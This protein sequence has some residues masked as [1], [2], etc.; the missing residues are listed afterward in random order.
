[1]LGSNQENLSES[2]QCSPKTAS[3]F[4]CQVA[5]SENP[6]SLSG[7]KNNLLSPRSDIS[8]ISNM[9]ID[10]NKC[11]LPYEYDEDDSNSETSSNP[12]ISPLTVISL[13]LDNASFRTAHPVMGPELSPLFIDTSLAN[14]TFE[15]FVTGNNL[16]NN[17]SQ[18][19]GYA[20]FRH[21][22]SNIRPSTP[23]TPRPNVPV[24]NTCHFRRRRPVSEYLE[25]YSR[26]NTPLCITFDS[27]PK[28]AWDYYHEP[29]THP[30]HSDKNHQPSSDT[31]KPHNTNGDY[32]DSLKK[33]HSAPSVLLS[34]RFQNFGDQHSPCDIIHYETYPMC[35]SDRY[36]C[37]A[38]SNILEENVDFIQGM[39][40]QNDCMFF[41]W[42]EEND[43]GT[44]EGS[45]IQSQSQM[46]TNFTYQDPLM[47]EN[48]PN[49]INWELQL[50][51]SI[52]SPSFQS[53]NVQFV[54]DPNPYQLMTDT[55][56]FGN[57]PYH[58][59]VLQPMICP[60]NECGKYMMQGVKPYPY[61]YS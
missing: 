21:M 22:T 3:L 53:V 30:E 33:C 41:E 12:S 10:V 34:D 54:S 4:N 11:E 36:A 40:S 31:H 5:G 49:H 61:Y 59:H 45:T 17:C 51:L 37:S 13:D 52:H 44:C 39:V 7:E 57:G 60:C 1:M 19:P 24:L 28:S 47:P 38:P 14:F 35:A 25:Y 43:K 6:T 50:P 27:L 46:D 18:A 23:R 8:E 48:G 42:Q 29:H 56:Y 58:T 20:V 2:A 9:D 55:P 32:V 26:M 16:L 15:R